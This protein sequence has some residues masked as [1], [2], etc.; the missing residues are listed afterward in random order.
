[1][2]L[3]EDHELLRMVGEVQLGL[4]EA[5]PV[6][7]GLQV[8][9]D[10]WPSLGDLQRQRRLAG[11]PRPEEGDG[12]GLIQQRGDFSSCPPLYHPCNSIPW[13]KICT[14]TLW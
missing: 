3:V 1:M 12:R 7:G 13:L 6:R 2:D 14:E 10:R 8:Q 5:R 11:L 4:G 9:V